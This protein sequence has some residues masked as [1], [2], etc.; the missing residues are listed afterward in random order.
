[1]GPGNAPQIA[2]L[3]E[4][5]LLSNQLEAFKQKTLLT[6]SFGTEKTVGGKLDLGGSNI[7]CI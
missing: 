4:M 2:D 6:L 5:E 3:Q 7:C 1:M